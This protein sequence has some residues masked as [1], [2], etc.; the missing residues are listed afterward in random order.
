MKIMGCSRRQ[1]GD[2]DSVVIKN[3]SLEGDSEIENE[4]KLTFLR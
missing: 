3:E 2:F 4:Q 1:S